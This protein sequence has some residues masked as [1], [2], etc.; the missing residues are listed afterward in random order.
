M[1][2]TLTS[3][4]TFETSAD[5]RVDAL[6]DLLA[7]L[8]TRYQPARRFFLAA[9]IEHATSQAG[10]ITQGARQLQM[11]R[12]GALYMLRIGKQAKAT[13]NAA[14]V[15][16]LLQLSWQVFAYVNT[17]KGAGKEFG[18]LMGLAALRV[19]PQR[20]VYHGGPQVPNRSAA[21][22]LIH[23]HRNHLASLL[24]APEAA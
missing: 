7:G 8:H 10:S 4:T 21:A 1:S 16:A 2:T 3:L 6:A 20:V 23:I 24:K 12:N 5:R 15:E 9:F 13:L 17:Y 22:K 14:Q 18:R 19:A 11:E